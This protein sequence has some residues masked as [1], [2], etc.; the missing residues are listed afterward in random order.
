MAYGGTRMT[1]IMDSD[2]KG[3]SEIA[4][5]EYIDIRVQR[6]GN[7]M[8]LRLPCRDDRDTW[9]ASILMFRAVAEGRW[10]ACI[11]AVSYTGEGNRIRAIRNALACRYVHA[12]KVKVRQAASSE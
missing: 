3:W 11:D 10:Q 5:G 8:S 7:E 9:S 4:R 6:A 12:G 1:G 2:L